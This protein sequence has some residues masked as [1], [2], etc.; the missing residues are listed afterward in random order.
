VTPGRQGEE[1]RLRGQNVIDKVKKRQEKA[2]E[3]DEGEIIG[4]VKIETMANMGALSPRVGPCHAAAGEV[5]AGLS[6]RVSSRKRLYH[7][8]LDGRL[9]LVVR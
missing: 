3:N 6:V 5:S 7:K 4:V 8:Y 9:R 2:K 1:N